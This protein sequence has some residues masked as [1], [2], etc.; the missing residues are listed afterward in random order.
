MLAPQ[1]EISGSF[2]LGAELESDRDSVRRA[3][4]LD[5]RD[6]TTHA[7]CIGMTG[8]G[9]TGLSIGLLEEAALDRVPAIIIDPKGDMG[10]LLLHFPTLSAD[11]FLP[12]IN[13]DECR[14]KGLSQQQCADSIATKW[15]QGLENWG[16]RP[17]RLRSL[18]D[19]VHYRVFTPGSTMVR[20]INIL[21]RLDPPPHSSDEDLHDRST[22]I[23]S[24]LLG[25]LGKGA[26]P[27]QSREL[28]FLA[29]LIE[30]FWKAGRATDIETLIRAI[31]D[32]P[33][34]RFGVFDVDTFFPED[35]RFRFAMDF[36]NLIASP[37]FG[38]WMQGDALDISQLLFDKSGR[39]CHS[40]FYLAHLSDVERMFFVT[41]LL[42]SLVG[43]MR[44]QQGTTSLRSLLYFDEVLGF[45][46]PVA[47]PPSKRPL[48]TILKQGRAFGLGAVLATQNPVDLDYKAL[49]NAGTWFIGRLQ[50][51][52]DQERL[53]RGVSE[54]SSLSQ[55]SRD[56]GTLL[57][58]LKKR[59]FVFHSVHRE[60]PTL[61]R[62][63]WAMNY[64]RGPLAREQLL[65]L[66]PQTGSVSGLTAV[67]R[68]VGAESESPSWR[69]EDRPALEPGIEEFF[70]ELPGS[71]GRVSDGSFRAAL[72]AV[73]RI[74]FVNRKYHVQGTVEE[75]L[76]LL[77]DDD[78][79]NWGLAH[80]IAPPFLLRRTPPNGSRYLGQLPRHANT[81]K[82]VMKATRLA[83]EF[84]YRNRSTDLLLSEETGV[85]QEPGEPVEAFFARVEL[86]AREMRDQELDG[87][88]QDSEAQIRRLESRLRDKS[89]VVE[90]RKEELEERYQHEMVGLA[91]SVL[92]MVFGGRKPRLSSAAS[93]RR[94]TSSARRRL[95]RSLVEIKD[96]EEEIHDARVSVER[97]S[98]EI[99]TRWS[100]SV[101][102]T[103][104]LTVA[105]RRVD[106]AIESIGVF[107][108][109]FDA[110]A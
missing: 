55:S 31:P 64:L 100:E 17:E 106:V 27:A 63:R 11:E 82:E 41:L 38:A 101:S 24:G 7:V 110:P 61:F 23:A 78:S 32:P 79:I 40:I 99:R 98:N 19:S 22:G 4:H 85:C 60:E 62:T 20:P 46:P 13:E 45:L 81:V 15:R 28:T 74:S 47:Q 87:L 91:E 3:F 70:V 35:E 59:V 43:W 10:N 14:R 105:P 49:S 72:G 104:V 66:Q 96:I 36:N 67:S 65:D 30:H 94:T 25:L 86:A 95:D 8:S 2:F 76:L 73:A 18:R 33:V 57:S 54:S 93:R 56:L 42:E 103:Q 37:S 9:K 90:D 109:R 80:V 58:S 12:W 50:S 29:V 68:H 83:K 84:L 107:W 1:P 77:D 52:Q 5:A 89:L 44:G 71:S 16:I 39:P 21:G 48:L 51:E 75:L 26:V 102:S 88:M 53:L 92:G 6:L 69:L 97:E 108:H 34:R